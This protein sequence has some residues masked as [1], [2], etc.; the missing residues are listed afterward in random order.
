MSKKWVVTAKK[1][2]FDR[3][4]QEF[5]ISPYL[6]RIIRNRDAVTDEQISMYLCADISM[7]HDPALLKDMEE[8]ASVL[9]DAIEAQIPIRIVGDYDIDGVCASY[10]LKKGIA[11][12]GGMADVRLPERMKD[13]YGINENIIRQAD[14]D[15]IELIITCDNGIAAADEIG[16]ASSL[17]MSAIVTDHHEVPYEEKDGKKQYRIPF[18][19]AVI[20]PKRPDDDYPFEGICGGMVAYKLISYL[21]NSTDIGETVEGK[22]KLLEEFLSFAAF[23]TVGDLMELVDENRVAVKRG[24]EILKKTENKGMRALMEATGTDPES[25]SA[26]HIGFVLGPCI[27][28]TGRLE[29]ADAALELFFEDSYEKALEAARELVKINISRRNL[30]DAF[31][32]KAIA[33]VEEKYSDDKVLVVYMPDC[34]QSIAGIVAGK[35]KEKFYKPSI[36]LTD[37]TD[38][39]IKGSARSIEAYSMYDELNKVRELFVKFGGHKMAAGL[40]MPAGTADELRRRLN[41]SCAL[42]D[43]DM[44][45]KMRID[46]PLPIGYV[47]DEFVSELDKLEPFGIA[48]PKPLFAEKNVKIKSIELA[49]TDRKVLRMRLEGPGRD[50]NYK[51]LPAVIFNDAEKAYED[52]KDKET[53]SILYQAGFNVYKGTKSVQLV[54]K[55]YIIP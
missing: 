40:S 5:S 13:G 20:D 54:I 31:T 23:A 51:S 49:G 4:A 25:L 14:E 55:D 24:L 17:G 37:D 42:T 43:D 44:I 47:S 7:M 46:I 11:A 18:A 50:G 53:V 32:N 45:E 35:L 29:T 48:N 21:Y 41:D 19:D 6:A 36:V 2:D 1:A 9:S 28:A 3:I 33:M 8:A 12:A 15:G 10:I 16:L 30:T 34:H 52:L 27:N 38:G 22:D 26:Y 39:N